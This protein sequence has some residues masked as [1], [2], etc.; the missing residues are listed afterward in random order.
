MEVGF[1]FLAA[2]ALALT[3][4]RS[5][6]AL[7]GLAGA[8]LHEAAHI[9][10][11]KA[12]GEL[13]REMRFTV[14][15]ID[16]V[17]RSER[18]SYVRDAL[19]SFAGPAANLAAAGLCYAIFQKRFAVFTAVNL[20]LFGLNIMPVAPL[21]GGQALR[22]LLL[23]KTGPEKAEKMVAAVSFFTLIPLAA[24]GFFVLLRTGRNF[25]LLLAVCYLAALLLLKRER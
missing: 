11:M 14:F 25:T 3:L 15:G 4:D 20:L 23:R 18:R 19:V 9:A 6:V 1:P 5:G 17:R 24:A 21:D 7:A 12:F 16:I 13:P 22:A 10:A 8:A 2:I